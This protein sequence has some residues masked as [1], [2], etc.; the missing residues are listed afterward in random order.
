MKVK[1]AILA[2]A[3]LLI[4]GVVGGVTIYKSKGASP[5]KAVA[6]AF[7]A[8]YPTAQVQM[9]R[10]VSLAAAG[11]AGQYLCTAL[12]AGQNGQQCIV[13]QALVQGTKA[14]LITIT[15]DAVACVFA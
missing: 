15:A 10:C 7:T 12:A 2:V 5:S 11:Y 13:I 1:I 3:L 14:R 9:R 8:K 4:A 6:A